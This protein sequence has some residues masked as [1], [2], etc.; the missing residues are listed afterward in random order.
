MWQVASLIAPQPED[1]DLAELDDDRPRPTPEQMR[2]RVRAY[3][4]SRGD[5]TLLSRLDGGG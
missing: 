1:T 5:E 3:A 2:E 4:A